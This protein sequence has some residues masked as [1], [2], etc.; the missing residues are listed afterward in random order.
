MTIRKLLMFPLLKIKISA[1]NI[2]S[3]AIIP[4]FKISDKS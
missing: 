1:N 3:F 2:D 4:D